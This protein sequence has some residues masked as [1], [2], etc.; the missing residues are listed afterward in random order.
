MTTALAE[1]GRIADRPEMTTAV[2]EA[3]RIARRL[4]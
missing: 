4:R 3:G 1:A 2:T